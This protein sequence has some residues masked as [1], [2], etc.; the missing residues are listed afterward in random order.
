MP[1]P[2]RNPT[3]PRI[4]ASSTEYWFDTSDRAVQLLKAVRRFRRADQEMRRGMETDMDINATDLE[5]LRHVI[6]HERAGTAVTARDL[7]THLHIS[8][9]ST[10]KLL[11]RLS[12]SGHVQ[13]LPHPEDRR[14]V[15][16]AATQHAHEEVRCWLSPMHQRML[17]A[18]RDVPEDSRQAVLD[19]LDAL[20]QSLPPDPPEPEDG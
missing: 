20:T 4:A 12:L 18:A 6:A 3:P 9:A 5:A 7:S 2:P 19:F 10:A 14:S 15:L 16:V 13:R 1:T 17:Q 11:N 8:T